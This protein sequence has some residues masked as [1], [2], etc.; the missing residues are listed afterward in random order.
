MKILLINIRYVYMGG[1]ERYM[2]NLKH[3]L[4][5]KGHTVIP[6]S[7]HYPKNQHSEYEE[8]FAPPIADEESILYKDQ[9]W[10][11]KSFIKTIERNFYSQ[12]VEDK[13]TALI[14]HVKPDFA[15][16][17]QYL[18]KL[19]PSV[20][21]ALS[22]KR[23]SFIV[24]LS[25]YGLICPSHNL[26]RDDSIC[27]LC[28]TG[29]LIN[30]IRYKCVHNSFGASTVNYLATKYHH[31]KKYFDLINHFVSPS[32]ALIQ[33]FVE[34]G[35]SKE[36]FS[37]LPTFANLPVRIT[38][39]EKEPKIVYAGRLEYVKGVHL[40]LESIQLL[41]ER[42]KLNFTL[43]I[44]GSGSAYY[45]ESL[46]SYCVTKNLREVEFL[47]E[48]EKDALFDLYESSVASIVP[49]LWYD[50][51]P[52]S[53]LESLSLGTPVIAP[54]HGCFPEF[55]FDG[56][57]GFLFKPCD[58]TDLAEKIYSIFSSNTDITRMKENAISSIKSNFS[59][60]LHYKRLMDI[61]EKVKS[62]SK[63]A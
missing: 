10:N 22:N 29:N 46:K 44:A 58:A 21:V 52:N 47:G 59:A 37:H 50:N 9:K 43:K 23:I 25:D 11:L 28:T 2:F 62:N 55:V 16:V 15:I 8:F 40:L 31:S 20:L 27:E 56:E 36:R 45:V 49:S 61:I 33:K 39:S 12:E 30:S 35:W 6:F 5:E 54:N 18:R 57:N 34:S 60:E 4:E 53:A 51:L 38:H 32:K 42:S 41:K 26:F 14:D 3:I 24:R 7:I 1:P 17:L 48:L 19:S 63:S 13:L